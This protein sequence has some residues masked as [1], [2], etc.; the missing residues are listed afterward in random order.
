M[1]RVGLGSRFFEQRK[2]I[3]RYF[4]PSAQ[5][6]SIVRCFYQRRGGEDQIF[7]IAVA[8]GTAEPDVHTPAE[9]YAGADSFR[10]VKSRPCGR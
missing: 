8:S 7:S 9:R 5:S 1:D 2:K 3:L 6:G 4:S 10:P